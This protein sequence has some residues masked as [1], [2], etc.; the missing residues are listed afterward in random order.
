M[1]N[2]TRAIWNTLP[3]LRAPTTLPAP[4]DLPE[5]AT[6]PLPA[7]PQ[8]LFDLIVSHL[9]HHRPSLQACALTAH[10]FLP[11]ARHQLFSTYALTGPTSASRLVTHF[12]SSPELLACIRTL[13]IRALAS[14][15]YAPE[16]DP[17]WLE[18]L[19][20]PPLPALRTLRLENARAELLRGPRL[21]GWA[22][23]CQEITRLELVSCVFR[24]IPHLA[25]LL[26]SFPHLSEL[27]WESWFPPLAQDDEATLHGLRLRQLC[28]PSAGTLG[29]Q[30]FA[31]WF[32][33]NAK[34]EDQLRELKTLELQGA[35]S[36][37]VDV[38]FAA[39]PIEDLR[40]HLTGYSPG[41]SFQAF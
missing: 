16:P 40:V 10:A 35:P 38:L 28:L 1:L 15:P 12:A 20:L 13:R 7:L 17:V 5:E 32:V 2:F 23:A 9:S 21:C 14:T 41:S 25:G 29:A 26:G 39:A 33:M 4:V 30:R 31:E 18:D 19:P 8:E 24:D 34:E 3:T 36:D 6:N 37:G 27:A 22:Q 11:A